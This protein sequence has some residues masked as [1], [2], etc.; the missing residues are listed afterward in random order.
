MAGYLTADQMADR[1]ADRWGITATIT[2]GD[3]DVASD[4]LD[5]SGPFRFRKKDSSQER[6]FP[7][8]LL[9]DGTDNTAGT[10]PEAVLDAVALLAHH[11]ASD[12][13]PAVTSESTLDRSVSY[14]SPKPA[15][16]E[17]RVAALLSPY[18]LRVGQR[19]GAPQ[20]SEREIFERY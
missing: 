15:Q 14:A 18:L 13:G 20:L 17:R 7:R 2:E 11:T 6:A 16:A 8:S 10:I 4:E 9:L 12:E 5:A 1:L 19:S 3:A